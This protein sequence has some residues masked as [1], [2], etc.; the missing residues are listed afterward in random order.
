MQEDAGNLTIPGLAAECGFSSAAT[1]QRIFKQ[2]T[3]TTPSRFM[4]DARQS[5]KI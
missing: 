1:F 5:E 4:Q 3:G 2:L